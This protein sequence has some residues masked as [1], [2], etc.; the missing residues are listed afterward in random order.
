MSGANEVSPAVRADCADDRRSTI[1]RSLLG[2]LA[3]A[4]PVY[5]VTSMTQGLLRP[6][7]DF[8]RHSWSL[9]ANGQLGWI[10]T[11][12][13][14]LSGAMVIAGAV[15]VRLVIGTAT[16]AARWMPRLLAGYGAGLV[17]AGLFTADPAD[18][19]PVGTPVG[20]APTISWHGTA[21]L[22][23]GGLGFAC[24]VAVCL[25]TAVLHR[26]RGRPAA[27]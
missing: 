16:R 4:G 13:L 20:Q 8:T 15:G 17:L 25:L 1:A 10:Q 6:G 26:A 21:H 18:G 27:P 14:I 7:F 12:N 22:M 19:F 3:L 5:L 2:W 24:L 11:L 9:L 23:V